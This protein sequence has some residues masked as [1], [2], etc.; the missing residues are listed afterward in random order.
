MRV[1]S[2]ETFSQVGFCQVHVMKWRA[3]DSKLRKEEWTH[4]RVA[5]VEI[6]CGL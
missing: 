6:R 3:M 1:H 5:D 2:E 4:M